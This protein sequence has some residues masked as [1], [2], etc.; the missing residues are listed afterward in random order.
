MTTP[1]R[2]PRDEE[3]PDAL[4]ACDDCGKPRTKAQGGTVFTVCDECWDRHVA[5]RV[6]LPPP[7]SPPRALEIIAQ[8]RRQIEKSPGI[9]VERQ[10]YALD[11][12]DEIEA[13]LRAAALSGGSPPEGPSP[14]AWERAWRAAN[15]PP[16]GVP[17][18]ERLRVF[19]AALRGAQP[20]SQPP[21]D[22]VEAA[23]RVL[24]TWDMSPL[25]PAQFED[26]LEALRAALG[27]HHDPQ[28]EGR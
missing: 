11:L 23:R 16:D 6:A 18:P 20:A 3:P 9:G 26:D 25:M 13:D 14:D 1:G 8:H 27:A 24:H 19:V 12:L 4:Y 10:T 28:Q 7:G 22:L 5:A 15:W 2:E 21:T 17:S